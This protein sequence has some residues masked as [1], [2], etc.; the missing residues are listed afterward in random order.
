MILLS[1]ACIAVSLSMFFVASDEVSFTGSVL[2]LVL[3]VLLL[4][5]SL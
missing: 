4:V 1:L 5:V 3:S 2:C